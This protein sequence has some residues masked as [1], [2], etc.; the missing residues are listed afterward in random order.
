VVALLSRLLGRITGAMATGLAIGIR[1]PPGGS[2]RSTVSR[3]PGSPPRPPAPSNQAPGASYSSAARSCDG[4]VAKASATLGPAGQRLAVRSWQ[5]GPSTRSLGE[6]CSSVPR[7]LDKSRLSSGWAVV[8]AVV[9][10]WVMV[11]LP[12]GVGGGQAAQ[13]NSG[14]A[15][16]TPLGGQ[17]LSWYAKSGC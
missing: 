13:M 10:F 17:H 14:G 2:P 6:R 7:L 16:Q 8:A 11:N 3:C 15:P 1:D 4:R 12:S 5:L 9:V